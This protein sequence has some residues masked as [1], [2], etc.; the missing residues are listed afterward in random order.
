MSK[1]RARVALPLVLAACAAL[2]SSVVARAE[3]DAQWNAKFEERFKGVLKP[4]TEYKAVVTMEKGGSFTILF[5]PSV[6]PNHVANFVSLARKG[7]YNGTS[8][9]RVIPGFMAQGGDPT[10]TGTGGPGYTIKAE[11][12]ATKHV[13]GTVSM[14]R[15]PD[16]DSAGS[17]F[18]ICF[19]DTPNL[20]NQYTVFGKV[21]EGM[22]VV[23]KIKPRDP[24]RATEPGDKIQ[25]VVI[26]EAAKP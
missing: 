4:K 11:F 6:A 17:Q 16:P 24:M 8:F 10:G 26:Q 23:D 1:P 7:F 9:H 12:N 15:K 2:V 22:D 18:F 13:R 14:A 19:G 21:I 20:D 5:D 25:T 3:D